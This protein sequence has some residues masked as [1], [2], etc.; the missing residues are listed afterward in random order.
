MLDQATNG[1]DSLFVDNRND[2]TPTVVEL[3]TPR[4][5]YFGRTG[6][7]HNPVVGRALRVSQRPITNDDLHL[8]EPVVLEALPSGLRQVGF[9]L[10]GYNTTFLANNGGE[11]CGVVPGAGADF[12]D[13]VPRF[14]V[15]QLQHGG[16]NRGL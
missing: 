6:G 7:Y 15:T 12:E 11:Q 13:P 14:E 5:G 10:D 2:Q 4:L 9:E 1:P 16:D 8:P 3:I